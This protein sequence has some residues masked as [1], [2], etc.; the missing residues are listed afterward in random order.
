RS[1]QCTPTQRASASF[2][3]QLRRNRNSSSRPAKSAESTPSRGA[4]SATHA[5]SSARNASARGEKLRSIAPERIGAP[6]SEATD[7]PTT[8]AGAFALLDEPF[9]ASGGGSRTRRAPRAKS[10]HFLRF[11]RR[12]DLPY[13]EPGRVEFRTRRRSGGEARPRPTKSSQRQRR[14]PCE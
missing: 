10:P 5:R 9:A 1:G 13:G 14:D 4:C 11:T 6:A 3:C 8:P 12:V 2:R 7:P